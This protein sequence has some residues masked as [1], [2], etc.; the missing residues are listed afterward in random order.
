MKPVILIVL[1]G[2][3]IAPKSNGN[4]I[5]KAHPNYIKSLMNDYPH[6]LLSASGL[7]V[8]LPEGEVGNTEVGHINLGAGRVVIQDLPRINASIS[9]GS[10]YKN[11]AFKRAITHIKKTNGK[12][13]ILG[14]IGK[15]HTHA[16]IDHLFALLHMAKQ[17]HCKQVYIHVITD[18]RDSSPKSA[19]IYLKKIDEFIKN[20]SIGEIV[21][22]TGRYFAMDRDHRWERTEKAYQAICGQGTNI[23]KDPQEAVEKSYREGKTDEFI[24]PVIIV[25]ESQVPVGPVSDSDA[26]IFL[27]YRPDR[28]RQLTKAFVL[29]DLTRQKTSSDEKIS[30]FQRGKKKDNLYFV[31][32][33]QY[34]KDLPVSKIAY[35]P[36]VVEMPITR[37]FSELGARQLHIAETEKYAHVTYFF[38]GGR[39]QPFPKEERILID[40]PKVASYDLKP[41]MSTPLIAQTLISKI[42]SNVYDF[43][44]CNFANADMVAHTGKLDATIKAVQVIDKHLGEITRIVFGKGGGLIITSDH[45]NAEEMIN[46]RT[47][48]IDTEHNI[49]PSPVIFAFQELRGQNTQFPQGLLADFAPSVLSLLQIPKPQQMTGRSLL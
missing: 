43:I 26:V 48:E 37:I 9:N 19:H 46:L 22:I 1:D 25:D 6:T 24:E 31:T 33:T 40:S 14:L 29:D 27:N 38:N 30:T 47:G 36:E 34:E 15:Y 4:A 13:H 35:E 18:G 39:E 45:G 42:N 5:E 10:F 2:Y 41:E 28:T 32:M 11:S 23:E 44:V 21:S 20:N 7:A 16:S 3:G 8:G 12:L 17:E 49:N